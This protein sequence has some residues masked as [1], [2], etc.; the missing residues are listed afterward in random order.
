MKGDKVHTDFSIYVSQSK[1]MGKAEYFKCHLSSEESGEEVTLLSEPSDAWNSPK[2]FITEVQ[3]IL[4]L[5]ILR[6][7][8]IKH[9][10]KPMSS[11]VNNAVNEN[12][13]YINIEGDIADLTNRCFANLGSM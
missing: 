2:E 3:S 7:E 1:E 12:L 11:R 10:D 5:M 13:H 9:Q 8:V 6:L 4:S